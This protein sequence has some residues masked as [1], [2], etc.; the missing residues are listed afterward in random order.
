ME[1]GIPAEDASVDFVV[2]NF[3]SASEISSDIFPEISR[4]L[5]SGGV[6]YLSFYNNSALSNTWW[7]P[8]QTSIE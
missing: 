6:A 8:G 5:T 2:A 7:Q 1:C 4:V 3:G